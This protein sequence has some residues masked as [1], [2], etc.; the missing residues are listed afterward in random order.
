MLAQWR[1]ALGRSRA[2][3]RYAE[4]GDP[5]GHNDWLFVTPAESKGWILDAICREIGS[6]QKG[7]WEVVYN[8]KILPKADTYFFAHYWNYLDHLKR[9]PH[10]SDGRVLVWYTHPREIPYTEQQQLDGYSQADCVIFTCSQFRDQWLARG[11]DPQRCAVVLGGADPELFKGH[12]RG[13]GLIGLSSSFYERKS[14]DTLLD[15]VRALPDKRFRLIGRKWEEYSRF[16]ELQA[17]ENFDYVTV[18]YSHYPEHYRQFDVFVSLATLEGGPI[19]LLEAM[20]D[21]IVPVA[22]RTGFAPDLID[23]G[24]NGFLFDVGS[25]AEVVAPLI[26]QAC[27]LKADIRLTVRPYGW[28]EFASVIHGLP[29]VGDATVSAGQPATSAAR[30]LVPEVQ[31]SDIAFLKRPVSHNLMALRDGLLN[32]LAKADPGTQAL[33]V[34]MPARTADDLFE[35]PAVMQLGSIEGLDIYPT[36]VFD[37]QAAKRAAWSQARREGWDGLV[38]LATGSPDD[39]VA[40][41]A[42]Q[43]HVAVLLPFSKLDKGELALASEFL[44]LPPKEPLSLRAG[45]GEPARTS[46]SLNDPITLFLTPKSSSIADESPPDQALATSVEGSAWRVSL[47]AGTPLRIE[48]Q[49]MQGLR[50][51]VRRVPQRRSASLRLDLPLPLIGKLPIEARITDAAT[52]SHVAASAALDPADIRSDMLTAYLNRGGA[53]DPV[54]RAFADGVGC[55]LG[56]TEE[57][58]LPGVPVVWGVLRGSDLIL[59]E[60]RRRS[61]HFFYIDHAY[62]GRGHG[63]NYR[64]TRD[65]YE[66]GAVRDYPRDR[67]EALGLRLEPW[68]D[69]G[70]VVLICPPTQFFMDAHGC[71][72]WLGETMRAIRRATDRPIEVRAKPQPGEPN[73]PL[74]RALK[75]THAIVTHSSNVAVEAVVAGTPVFVAPTSAAAPVGETDL[76]RI[77]QPRRPD[78]EAWLAHLAYSQFTFAEI[79][80]GT[81]WR[82]L[83]EFERRSLM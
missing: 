8:P 69:G 13:G 55:D 36:L 19:P 73:E 70:S 20:M 71:P 33:V 79:A 15:L 14:P 81:A 40:G 59:A 47:P 38:D 5:A 27:D 77:E 52:G 35:T 61:R 60:A 34:V 82:L 56:L 2:P 68:R 42:P 58:L 26:R 12:K 29:R 21:N 45:S 67:A 62:F 72:D 3:A 25:P 28:D 57:G 78:R 7:S 48:A 54:V 37:T 18:P 17:L 16:S 30:S 23:H 22:S 41:L 44:A 74:A 11:M 9:N 6:R 10:I 46:A 50:T 43:T 4:R 32:R 76:S 63:L 39:V 31:P 24:R 51:V 75:R 1:D 53:G 65:A 83:M 80:D 64:I 66:A 49:E